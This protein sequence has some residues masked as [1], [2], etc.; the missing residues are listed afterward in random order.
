M[1]L[2]LL[3]CLLGLGATVILFP[4]GVGIYSLVK[5]VKE[6]RRVK[7]MIKRGEFL[8]PIDIKDYDS[9]RWKDEINIEE[10]KVRVADLDKDLFKKAREIAK[11]KREVENGTTNTNA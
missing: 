8:H 11:E 6:R 3:G 10:N 1:N 4:I 2:I 9:E 7:K 5:N